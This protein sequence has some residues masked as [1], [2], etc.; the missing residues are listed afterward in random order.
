M[1]INSKKCFEINEKGQ[2]FLIPCGFIGNIPDWV[3]KHWLV[4]AAIQDGSIA[5]PEDKSDKA[6]EKAN[7]NAS[8]K[9]KEY[10]VRPD[11]NKKEVEVDKPLTE[12]AE[13]KQPKK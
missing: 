2:K 8:E 4:Q 6:I 3:A 11:E 7:R 5:T 13:G 1:F 12:A 10:D 9:A